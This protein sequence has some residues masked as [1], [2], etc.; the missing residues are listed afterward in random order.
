MKKIV[1]RTSSLLACLLLLVTLLPQVPVWAESVIAEGTCGESV[2]WSLSDDGVLTVSGSGSMY[3]Y[4]L[5]VWGDGSLDTPWYEHSSLITNVVIQNGVTGIGG[6][7]FYDCRNL[8]SITIADSLTRIGSRAFEGCSSLTSINI[9][10]GVTSIGER[11]FSGC[12]SLT[13]INIPEGVTNIVN[14]AF[15][16]CSSLTSVT[17][18]DS[19]TRIGASAFDVRISAVGNVS[20]LCKL[21]LSHTHFLTESQ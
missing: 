1:K 21:G 5:D 4:S 6:Y 7:A 20:R 13:S 15:S 9:P 14:Y 16:G 19:V 10:E 17:I 18:P 3:D 2:S 12:S 11:T 8:S